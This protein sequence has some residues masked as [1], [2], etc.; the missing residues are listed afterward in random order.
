MI[1]IGLLRQENIEVQIIGNIMYKRLNKKVPAI[2][3]NLKGYDNHL[4]IN[5]IGKF[6]VKVDVI[7]NGLVKHMAVTM[8]K[9]LV[10]IDSK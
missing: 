1:W 4:I 3:H 2:F 7:P 8:N 9:N 5:E 6:N 10:F